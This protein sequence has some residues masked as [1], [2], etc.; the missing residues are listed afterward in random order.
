MKTLKSNNFT[1]VSFLVA[2]IAAVYLFT[3]VSGVYAGQ[4]KPIEGVEYKLDWSFEDN[5]KAFKGK[6]VRVTL[7]SGQQMA[8]TV[9]EVK[10]GMLHIEK[11]TGRDF[12]DALIMI[13]D[14]SAIDTKFRGY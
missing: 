2:A 11:L 7:S 9:K 1:R 13:K 8:G 5:L 14:I 6:Y 4:A 3:A 10:N 12:F